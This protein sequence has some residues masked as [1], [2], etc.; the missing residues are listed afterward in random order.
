MAYQVALAFALEL[1]DH[2]LLVTNMSLAHHDYLDHQ[3][4][5]NHQKMI[6]VLKIRKN[7]P[8]KVFC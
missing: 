6:K 8:V 5:K 7:Y 4:V 1:G 2:R 3:S